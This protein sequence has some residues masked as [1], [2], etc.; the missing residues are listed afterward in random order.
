MNVELIAGI[1]S[2]VLIAILLRA[3]RKNRVQLKESIN[4]LESLLTKQGAQITEI[5]DDHNKYVDNTKEE[6]RVVT[7]AFE[8]LNAT[9]KEMLDKENQKLNEYEHFFN[10]GECLKSE[11]NNGFD[12]GYKKGQFDASKSQGWEVQIFPWKE[13]IEE[14]AFFKKQSVRIG[15]KYQ[16]F[17]NGIPC[18]EPHVQIHETLVT[19]KLD[20]DSINIAVSSLKEA[21]N[22]M[23]NIHP[24]IKTIG[25][26]TNLAKSLLSMVKTK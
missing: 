9:H 21:M 1:I 3:S 17:V 5:R 7:D 24:A 25:D 22:A 10:R 12:A 19:T 6:F 2:L 26:G 20:A 14:G 16:L 4:L 11:Y 13:D 18:F 23:S 8:K 15:F